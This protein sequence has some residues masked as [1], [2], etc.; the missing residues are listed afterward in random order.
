MQGCQDEGNC[1]KKVVLV[2]PPGKKRAKRKHRRQAAKTIT[3]SCPPPKI[4]FVAPTIS[5]PPGPAGPQGPIGPQGPAGPAGGPQGPVGP[6]GPQGN[7]GPAGPMGAQG[8][9]G[10]QGPIGPVGPQGLIGPT[11]PMGLQGPMGPQGEMGLQGPIGPQGSQGIQGEQGPQGIQGPTG[12]QGPPG[13]TT[14]TKVV[15]FQG[16]NAGFQLF[17]GSPGPESGT[18]PY[19]I[20][21][22]GSV[23]GVSGTIDVN[24]LGIGSYIYEVCLNVVNTAATPL[25][26]NVVATVTLTVTAPITGTIIFSSRAT[27]VGPH[28]VLVSNGAPY[29]VT[30]ATVTWTSNIPG[31]PITRNTALSLFLNTNVSNSA[32]YSVYVSTDI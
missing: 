8:E 7:A 1:Q 17:V 3:L 6:Q 5:G 10:P 13:T 25:P 14:S 2:C 20:S 22:N 12:A 31:T 11:G 19:V 23:V 27:D 24:N 18:I 16:A 4:E 9:A 32:T 26:A 28:P 15:V 30:S 29:V 21:G